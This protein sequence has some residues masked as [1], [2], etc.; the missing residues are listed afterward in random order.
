MISLIVVSLTSDR[1]NILKLVVSTHKLV[2]VDHLRGDMCFAAAAVNSFNHFSLAT[3]GAVK[4]I[5]VALFLTPEVHL[6]L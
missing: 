5:S 4:E 1:L 6:R 3:I 2:T